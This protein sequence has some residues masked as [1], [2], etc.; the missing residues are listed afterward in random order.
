M[1]AVWTDEFLEEVM[2][3]EEK[4]QRELVS[5][6]E[7]LEEDGMSIE[8]VGKASNSETGIEAWKIKV[9]NE[10]ADHRVIF[11]IIDGDIVLIAAGHR[12]EVYDN[13]NWKHIAERI[14]E[15]S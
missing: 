2:E 13:K 9:K 4:V 11:D 7:K 10:E 14:R 6:V 3:L 12:D 15:Q 1:R 5:K 8:E